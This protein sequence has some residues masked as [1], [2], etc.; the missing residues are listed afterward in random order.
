L[1]AAE[2][3]LL[4]VEDVVQQ[5]AT[6]IDALKRQAR[7]AIRY[8]NVA[9]ELRKVEATLHYLRWQDANT[10]VAEADRARD[11]SVR[12][13]AEATIS[14][15]EAGKLREETAVAVPPL[16]DAEARAAAALQRITIA[17]DTLDA[18]EA[19]AR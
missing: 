5:L 1:K 13:V 15:T 14:Q 12:A 18:E 16:R 10:E 4:R 17:R 2:T 8:R 19:R 6:Q 11:L 3:N 9:A 7:Q